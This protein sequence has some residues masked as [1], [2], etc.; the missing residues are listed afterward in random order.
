MHCFNLFQ[1][2]L[3]HNF[4]GSIAELYSLNSD[5]TGIFINLDIFQSSINGKQFFIP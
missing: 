4:L 2:H 5:F 3:M 1:K